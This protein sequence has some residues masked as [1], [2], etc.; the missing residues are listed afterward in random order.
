[1]TFYFVDSLNAL[2]DMG[3]D[4]SEF[5]ATGGGAKSDAWLQIK[6]DILGVPFV[7]PRITEGSV[8]GAAI[9][10]GVATG[11]FSTPAEGVGRFVQRDRVFEPDPG[12]HRMYMD[13]LERYQR[14][15]PLLHELLREL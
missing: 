9:L 13:N 7:R 6:A 8:L 5:V 11:I 2:H 4:T 12:R 14:L 15:L 10:A 3:V 1:V